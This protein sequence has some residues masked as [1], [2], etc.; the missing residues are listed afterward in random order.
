MEIFNIEASSIQGQDIISARDLALDVS[1]GLIERYTSR[2]P[3]TPDFQQLQRLS[4]ANEWSDRILAFQRLNQFDAAVTLLLSLDVYTKESRT[5]ETGYDRYANVRDRLTTPI[6][7]ADFLSKNTRDLLKAQLSGTEQ[8]IIGAFEEQGSQAVAGL[9]TSEYEI[10]VASRSIRTFQLLGTGA[11][12]LAGPVGIIIGGAEMVSESMQTIDNWQAGNPGAAAGHGIQAAA[13]IL[14]IAVAS[15]ECAALVTG[16][17]VAA[18][19]GPVGWIAAGLMLI[20]SLVISI[21]SK[22]DLEMFA[23]HSFLG[24]EYGDG[25]WDDQTGKAWMSG[26]PWPWFRYQSAGSRRESGERWQRQRIVLLRMI[27][28]FKTFIGYGT[29]CGG[30]VYPTFLSN[31]SYFDI[32]VDVMPKDRTSPKETFRLKVWPAPRDHVWIGAQPS[33][34]QISFSPESGGTVSSFTIS[35]GPERVS[36]ELYDY[37][38]RIRLDLDG[39]RQNYLPGSGAYLSNSTRDY[40]FGGMYSEKDSTSVD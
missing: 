6:K 23:A 9:S 39:N 28:S 11:R 29:F 18:W 25:D 4:I 36:A 20:G 40:G 37:V 38:L 35:A 12:I 19:A 8:R 15:A 32:E 14:I 5:Y 26:H 22:N 27:S 34:F 7:I 31:S 17:A 3:Q 30:F 1:A 10:F 2:L 13:G 16:A 24:E 33:R 21:W